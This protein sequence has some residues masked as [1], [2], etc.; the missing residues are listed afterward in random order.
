MLLRRV[1]SCRG[2]G[3]GASQADI[4]LQQELESG[5]T[6]FFALM[7]SDHGSSALNAQVALRFLHHRHLRRARVLW[8]SPILNMDGFLIGMGQAGYDSNS[9]KQ[10]TA[11]PT[12]GINMFLQTCGGH[13]RAWMFEE[14]A[15]T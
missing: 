3:A 1:A 4:Q 10:V 5:A 14:R 11:I 2:D 7:M 9:I 13:N 12:Q 6:D 8:Q 15:R